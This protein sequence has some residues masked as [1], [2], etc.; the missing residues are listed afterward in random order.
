MIISQMYCVSIC[1]C[2]E[3][4]HCIIFIWR[5]IQTLTKLYFRKVLFGSSRAR[6]Q[7]APVLPLE[8]YEETMRKLAI[9]VHK[10]REATKKDGG[11]HLQ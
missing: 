11:N 7:S 8:V 3:Y 10:A 6:G 2:V 4:L 1:M 9:T 5:E